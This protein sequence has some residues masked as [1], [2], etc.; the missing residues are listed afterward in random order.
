MAKLYM[1]LRQKITWL[2]TYFRAMFHL[3]N[4]WKYQKTSSFRM[5]AAV[6]KREQ[7]WSVIKF[8]MGRIYEPEKLRIRTLLT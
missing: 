5:F 3:F 8:F 4:P 1:F 7:N 6:I 2:V